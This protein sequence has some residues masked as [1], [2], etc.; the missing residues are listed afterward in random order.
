MIGR[1]EGGRRRSTPQVGSGAGTDDG[2]ER[3]GVGWEG[4]LYTREEGGL[5]GLLA[6]DRAG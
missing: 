3:V 5:H 1:E 2:E 6:E 4:G